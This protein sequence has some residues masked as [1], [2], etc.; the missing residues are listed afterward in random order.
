MRKELVKK[1]VAAALKVRRHARAPYSG[2]MVGAAVITRSGRIF[3]GVNVENSSFGAT[4][5][6]ERVALFSAITA[7]RGDIVAVVVAATLDG[8]AVSPCGICRQTLADIDPEMRVILVNAQTGEIEK[9]TT[10]AALLPDRFS[11][12]IPNP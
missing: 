11:F 9:E 4:V 10:V 7:G 3:T 2:F 6:A 8:H 12:D 1:A 5:C